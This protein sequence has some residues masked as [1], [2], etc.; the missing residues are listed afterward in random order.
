[1]ANKGVTIAITGTYNGRALEKA[2]Q[3]LEKMRI[4]AVAESG[5][6]GSALVTLGSKAA[7]LGGQL[8]NVGYKMEQFGT[9][10]TTYITLPIVAAGVACANAAIEIDDSLTSVKKTVDGTEEQYQQLKQAAIEFSKTNAVSASQILDIQAL[11]AQLGYTIDELDMFSRVVSGLSISTDMDADTAA[12][13]LAQFANITKMAH[14]E[15]EQYGST[16]VALGNNLA[17]TESQ[18]SAMA[19]RLAAAGTQ[20]GMSEADILG[21]AG[22]LTSLGLNA[23]AG[24]TAIS[25]IM[26]TVD[27]QVALATDGLEEWARTAGVSIDEML[28]HIQDGDDWAKK[29]AE[30]QG[31]TL[32]QLKGE[33]VVALESLTTWA[34]AAQMSASDF[35]T[36]WKT[37]PVQ[38]LSMLL[39]GM[40]D[41]T[42]EG[43]NMS[44]ML[45]DLGITSI[46]QT[47][48]MKRMA[49]NAEL[50]AD[51]VSLAND[52]W[53]DNTALQ[54]EVD[55]RNASMSSRLDILKNKVTAVAESVG[56]PLV[57]A[58]LEVIDDMEPLFKSIGEAAQAF[59][60]MD[61]A[62]QKNVLTMAAL[63]AGIGPVA[64]VGGKLL[65]TVGNMV[66]GFGKVA[67]KAGV[68]VNGMS[69]A[70]EACGGLGN[71]LAGCATGTLELGEAALTAEG[72]IS[73]AA[74]ATGTL[75]TVLTALPIAAVAAG[76]VA[77][78][79]DLIK[80]YQQEQEH[81]RLLK[82]ATEGINDAV[83]AGKEAYSSYM[84]AS[85]DATFSLAEF[86]QESE[87]TLAK[88]AELAQTMRDTW[89]DVGTESARLDYYVG[90][91]EELGGKSN[92]SATEVAK[93]KDAVNNY[94]QIT[95]DSVQVINDQTGELSK[96]TKAI[97]DN[98]E[99]YKQRAK[100]AAA[101]ELLKKAIEQRLEVEAQQ[102]AIGKE[103]RD[104]YKE[105][106][107]VN[108][109]MQEDYDELTRRINTLTETENYYLEILAATPSKFETL[110][111]ALEQ[112]GISWQEFGFTSQEQWDK[113]E[114]GF[115]GSLQSILTSVKEQ[116]L[117]IPRALSD[118]IVAATPS[119]KKA[120]KDLGITIVE[121]MADGMEGT[122]GEVGDASTYVSDTAKKQIIGLPNW[123]TDL[124]MDAASAL[125]GGMT[126]NKIYA[127]DAGATLK[128]S[129][130]L[131][132]NSVKTQC[133]TVGKTA[134]SNFGGGVKSYSAYSAGQSVA[135]TAK[136]GLGSVS[137]RSTGQNF[138]QGFSNGMSGINLF[139][140]AYNLGLRALSGIKSALGVASPSKEAMKVGAW[141]GEGAVIGMQSTEDA[142]AQEALRMSD[143][144]SLTPQNHAA[145]AYGA[146]GANLTGSTN[147]FNV[148]IQ[149]SANNAAEAATIGRNIGNE[150]YLQYVRRER[151][152]A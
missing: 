22:A 51:A 116:G 59:A 113:M 35:A 143:A 96:N 139:N 45:E 100:A 44:L 41:A 105:H 70:A 20:V 90:V 117:K 12:T 88:Q 151:G 147:I 71:V 107:V 94:N 119:S 95:G 25:T 138:A 145:Y 61:E 128:N 146:T 4:T 84:A 148:N 16:I 73:A 17:T 6:A 69:A 104:I 132:L 66:T 53:Q 27:K 98:A 77:L 14:S 18:V 137:A 24:G 140:V 36:A 11:G 47:D 149:V 63:A 40:E 38:A 7:E 103:I 28:K 133:T 106:G 19:Q 86:R 13:E 75:S 135:K 79:A 3:D 136:N 5:G 80:Q 54:K 110:Q 129:A 15:T 131:G 82:E 32:K 115:D 62:G 29:F 87:N 57:N 23:E 67:Q 83:N 10:A 111:E 52:A 1:M 37:D 8:H 46:R 142:I 58:L 74:T 125:A 109:Q 30:S 48:A 150:L 127:A 64:T 55:N 42:A 123:L 76:L 93:L 108:Q 102:A 141:F 122:A 101:E 68:F 130:L 124:G 91:I 152:Y 114:E 33:T 89:A 34:D 43:S 92:L 65:K 121:H 56:T 97:K 26:S 31:M 126:R 2:R 81:A 112:T 9:A 144:M 78:G 49:G 134:A 21:L 85:E 99:G 60:D 120:A 39:A 118:A 50:V 72:G